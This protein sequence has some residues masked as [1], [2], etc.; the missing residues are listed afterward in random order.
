MPSG[1]L[2][3]IMSTLTSYSTAV[4]SMTKKDEKLVMVDQ[5]TPKL[6]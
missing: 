3:K 4:P 1:N 6:W 5:P 2:E